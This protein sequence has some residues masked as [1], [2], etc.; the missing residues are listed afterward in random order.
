MALEWSQLI[1]GESIRANEGGK[2][3]QDVRELI[4]R[5]KRSTD[6]SGGNFV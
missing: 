3:V 5:N 6:E 2:T 4:D 1:R